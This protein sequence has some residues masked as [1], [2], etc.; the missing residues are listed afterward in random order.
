MQF[1]ALGRTDDVGNRAR[2]PRFSLSGASQTPMR[3]RG[4]FI[5]LSAGELGGHTKKMSRNEPFFDFEGSASSHVSTHR[6]GAAVLYTRV[7]CVRVI[8]YRY[9]LSLC[10]APHIWP[11]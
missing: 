2:G 10:S 9:R 7:S 4:R 3:A 1:I 11:T 5:L 6:H 8:I